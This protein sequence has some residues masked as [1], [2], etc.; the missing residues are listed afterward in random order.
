MQTVDHEIRFGWLD[1][2][3]KL[4]TPSLQVEPLPDWKD[5]IAQIKGSRVFGKEFIHLP[6]A[7][8]ADTGV[9]V[10]HERMQLPATHVMKLPGRGPEESRDLYLTAVLGFL[11]GLRLVPEGMG[12]LHRVRHKPRDGVMFYSDTREI[13]TCMERALAVWDSGGPEAGR[14]LFGAVHWYLT[15][16]AGYDHQF[17][18]FGF[19]YTVLDA[20]HVAAWEAYPAYCSKWRTKPTALPHNVPH[21]IRVAELAKHFCSPEPDNLDDLVDQRNKLMH[22]ARLGGEAIGFVANSKIHDMGHSLAF[23]AEQIILG[24]LGIPC[25]YRSDRY[26]RQT[27]PL[28]VPR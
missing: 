28:G 16:E 8:E 11:L 10:P 21:K 12:H 6:V 17:E 3:L 23:F 5:Q 1:L 18:R 14:R 22:E 19:L 4:D 7:P 25:S 15:A 24:L 2:R 13:T 26:S 20:L 9:L 27:L